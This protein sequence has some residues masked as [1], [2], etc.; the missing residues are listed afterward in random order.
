MRQNAGLFKALPRA[1]IIDAWR[2]WFYYFAPG[3]ARDDTRR[4]SFMMIAGSTVSACPGL[5]HNNTM[6]PSARTRR[7]MPRWLLQVATHLKNRKIIS[8]L[9]G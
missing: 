7:A 1:A 4:A 3:I 6:P 5:P 8:S 2:R 9:T